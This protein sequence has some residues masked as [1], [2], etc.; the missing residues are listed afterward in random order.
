MPRIKL[1]GVAPHV[2]QGAWVAP[3]ATL[4]GD[5]H[6]ETGASV[7]YGVVIRADCERIAIGEHI[8]IQ[9]GSVLH[10]DPNLPVIVG[11][12]VSVGHGAILHGCTI[13]DDVLVGM[14]AIVLNGARI[15]SGCLIAAGAVVLEGTSVPPNSL[16]AGVPGKVRRETTAAERE[17]TISNAHTYMRL[18]TRHAAATR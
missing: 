9:D 6:V 13:E 15:G 1:E 14:G 16:I 17:N 10:A 18:A 11:N 5:V 3:E 7:W 2:E 8:N 12:R 4:I